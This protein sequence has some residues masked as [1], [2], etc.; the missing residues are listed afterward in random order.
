M[1]RSI[2]L[3]WAVARLLAGTPALPAL[4]QSSPS[5][6]APTWHYLALG[7]S[8]AAGDHCG[9][10]ATFVDLWAQG[11]RES[12]GHEIEVTSFMN[13]R[14]PGIS[15]GPETDATLLESLRFNPVMRD[16][17][18]SADIIL[19]ESGS[20]QLD[21]VFFEPPYGW[22]CTG[23]LL[24]ECIEAMG[25]SGHANFDAILD[26]IELLRAGKPTAVRLVSNENAFLSHPEMAEGLGDDFA[27]TNGAFFRE[28]LKEAQCDAADAHGAQCVDVRPIINGPSMD[29]PGDEMSPRSCKPSPTR[30]SRPD[31]P[32]WSRPSRFAGPHVRRRSLTSLPS[33]ATW[34]A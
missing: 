34:K 19:I 11:L 13:Q 21:P 27:M 4:G 26:E 30:S 32:S 9:G 5:P 23:E 16:A 2:P 24:I 28:L 1:R 17:V 31:C 15:G 22:D 29:Q 14:E 10:C 12:T 33:S 18:R 20:N 6:V 7:D 8:W 25:R 3:A